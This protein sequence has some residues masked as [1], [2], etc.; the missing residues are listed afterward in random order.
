MPGPTL[1]SAQ[2][3]LAPAC[4]SRSLAPVPAWTRGVG[5][6]Q[7]SRCGGLLA[8]RPCSPLAIQ[9]PP[10]C[11][12]RQGSDSLVD[13][14]Q[15]TGVW[16]AGRAPS[17]GSLTR[18]PTPRRSFRRQGPA[19]CRCPGQS[20][21][22]T[23]CRSALRRSSGCSSRRVRPSSAATGTALA[24]RR[25]GRATPSP[26]LPQPQRGCHALHPYICFPMRCSTGWEK[27][28]VE[29]IVDRV[30]KG[31][32]RTTEE[33]ASAVVSPEQTGPSLAT[34]VTSGRIFCSSSS[35]G[36]CAVGATAVQPEQQH[37]G[38]ALRSRQS[39]PSLR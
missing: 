24:F 21:T 20:G 15:G 31:M 22:P 23:S 38:S 11:L 14:G 39:H 8:P 10:T 29:Q 18:R 9:A 19:T 2:Q 25:R 37:S 30:M 28:W 34:A 17:P 26:Q 3:G 36:T 27:P 13:T 1:L 6:A 16:P 5:P 32:L 4:R 35:A 7:P 12:L 33:R